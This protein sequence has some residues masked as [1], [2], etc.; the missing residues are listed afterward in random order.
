MSRRPPGFV[1]WNLRPLESACKPLG[2]GAVRRELSP[3][4]SERP[5][6]VIDNSGKVVGRCVASVDARGL[7]TFVYVLP[8]FLRGVK[9]D[10]PNRVA[11]FKVDPMSRVSLAKLVDTDLHK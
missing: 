9:V 8:E 10:L 7:R 1:D 3:K 5:H 11:C 4:A 6:A 2:C